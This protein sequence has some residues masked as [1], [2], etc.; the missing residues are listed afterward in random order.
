ML[1]PRSKESWTPFH[2]LHKSPLNDWHRYLMH[3]EH[4]VL[5][6]LPFLLWAT[7]NCAT[8][9]GWCQKRN[10]FCSPDSPNKFC[11]NYSLIFGS[12]AKGEKPT[13]QRSCNPRAPW[14]INV[15]V[16]CIEQ[17]LKRNQVI[18]T[19]LMGYACLNTRLTLLLLLLG[20][21]APWLKWEVDTE[22]Q[23]TTMQS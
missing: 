23:I 22:Y 17:Y 16:F 7:F 5:G 20:I 8:A 6:S 18:I 1:S 15:I 14:Y 10:L 11:I 4:G 19:G 21:R 3:S 9:G 13:L 2:F 12:L